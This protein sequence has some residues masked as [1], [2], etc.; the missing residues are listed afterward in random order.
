MPLRNAAIRDAY[1]RWGTK[2][3]LLG[4]D[5]DVIPERLALNTSFYQVE[6]IAA[7]IYYACLDG[8]WDAEPLSHVAPGTVARDALRFGLN[9]WRAKD[10]KSAAF[11]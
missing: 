2:W 6:H 11:M 7:D 10:A 9:A 3:V 1:A 4:G 5:T 8:N